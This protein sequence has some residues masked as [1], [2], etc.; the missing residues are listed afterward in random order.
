[1]LR[2]IAA[3]NGDLSTS[4]WLADDRVQSTAASPNRR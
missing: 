4:P 3:A 2:R 1:M